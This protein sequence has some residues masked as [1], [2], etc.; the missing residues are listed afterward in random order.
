MKRFTCNIVSKG[1]LNYVWPPF[2]PTFPSHLSK[3]YI[4]CLSHA[5]F[6]FFNSF[7]VGVHDYY[8]ATQ[9]MYLYNSKSFEL[10]CNG[11]N[12]NLKSHVIITV[13][14]LWYCLLLETI[15]VCIIYSNTLKVLCKA[16][17]SY[18]FVN[19]IFYSV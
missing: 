9:R 3:V 14:R 6:M 13:Y 12:I 16:S 11:F 19:L 4:F 15:F 17:I 10:L 8:Y 7:E 18:N 1:D 2:E 5:Q